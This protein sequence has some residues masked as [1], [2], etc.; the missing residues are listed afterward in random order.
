MNMRQA[1][2]TS[3]PLGGAKVLG[4]Y[5]PSEAGFPRPRTSGRSLKRIA[6][7]GRAT[8]PIPTTPNYLE[9][10][11]EMVAQMRESGLSAIV[12]EN[13]ARAYKLG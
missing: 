8:I 4:R 13:V 6:S 1:G 5:V 10:L 11:R 9:E 7:S 12:A 2:R 3:G